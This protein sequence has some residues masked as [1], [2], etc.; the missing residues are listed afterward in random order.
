MDTAEM[1][2]TLDVTEMGL[3]LDISEMNVQLVIEKTNCVGS[4]MPSLGETFRVTATITDL[5]GVPV[6]TGTDA[7]S[8]YD[9]GG[10]LKYT[11]IAPI[12]L[13]AGVWY[14]DFTTATTDTSGGWL[15]VWKKTTI[16][17]AIGIG[18]IQSFVDDPPI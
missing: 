13:G 6:T 12:H 2:M 16:A 15:I 14:A 1:G 9:P 4:Y 7:I 5:T 10:T 3:A 17:G 11:N 18:K 8:V